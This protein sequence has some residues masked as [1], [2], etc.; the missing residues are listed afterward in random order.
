MRVDGVVVDI[1][2]NMQVDRFK[3]HD[4]EVVI[5]G[6]RA[7]DDKQ[8]R[9]AASVATAFR[10]GNGF[11]Y[12]TMT[13]E[14]EDL[15]QKSWWIRFRVYRTRSHRPIVFRL[16]H[17]TVRARNV[18]DWV[19][20]F[21]SITTR[22]YPTTASRSTKR[23]PSLWSGEGQYHLR[24]AETL[25]K[26]SNYLCHT[27]QRH[28]QKALELILY[29][30]NP[31][32]KIVPVCYPRFCVRPRHRRP[33]QHAQAVVRRYQFSA[34]V[35]GLRNLWKLPKCSGCG[36]IACARSRCTLSSMRNTSVS[37]HRWTLLPSMNG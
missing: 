15:Q 3:T 29:G 33:L 21:R 22:S 11:S 23:H 6:L 13:R 7:D 1:E 2:A 19:R 20:C 35:P 26:N 10:L 17:L 9:I 4:I 14:G 25:P 8:P 32:V 31:R 5:D 37:W 12:S 27:G 24:P 30:E 18:R 16:T 36:V 34:S 28:S